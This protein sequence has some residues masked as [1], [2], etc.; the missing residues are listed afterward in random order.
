MKS[1][2][3]LRASALSDRRNSPAEARWST[4]LDQGCRP[5]IDIAAD[6]RENSYHRNHDCADQGN[7]YNF[8]M[9]GAISAV[10]RMI[11]RILPCRVAAG[12]LKLST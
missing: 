6:M 2:I 1:Q 12:G 3:P 9:G 11:H 5:E 4:G 7:N 10:Y 8:Q